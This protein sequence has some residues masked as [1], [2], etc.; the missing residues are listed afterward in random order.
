MSD[1]ICGDF[2]HDPNTPW[3]GITFLVFSNLGFAWT[4]LKAYRHRF[5]F[6]SIVY[7]IV[8]FISSFYHA[9]KPLNGW[10]CIMPYW[11]LY[12]Y[13]M[14]FALMNIPLV[15]HYFLPYHAPIIYFGNAT[16]DVNKKLAP[17]DSNK[18]AIVLIDHSPAS[19][20]L[21]YFRG[22][23]GKDIIQFVVYG[24]IIGLLIAFGWLNIY[25]YLILLG[26]VS[27]EVLVVILFV[28]LRFGLWPFFHL[29]YLITGIVLLSF[30]GISFVIQD[31]LPSSSYVYFYSIMHSLWHLVSAIGQNYLIDARIYRPKPDIL[32]H[33]KAQG[34][35]PD[36]LSS[37]H[38]NDIS[39][40]L[41]GN[42][43]KVR[44]DIR[45]RKHQSESPWTIV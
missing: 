20:S 11:I 6:N 40:N 18:D 13:D 29:G 35:D 10:F 33:L 15:T 1:H 12:V 37:Q 5:Y 44:S 26:F 3:W 32:E 39:L 38:V 30:G 41:Y 28:R 27:V 14:F 16:E 42:Q 25:G 19:K 34:Y 24:F 9:C 4:S 23:L 45:F 2:L 43:K 21:Y 22:F 36:H 8:L 7:L 17:R 31:F